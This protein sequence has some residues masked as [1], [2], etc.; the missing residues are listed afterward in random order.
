MASSNCYRRRRSFG[1]RSRVR[2]ASLDLAFREALAA[3]DALMRANFALTSA[4]SSGE[5][6]RPVSAVK[7]A[8]TSSVVGPS[9]AH[10]PMR[11]ISRGFIVI[12][13]LPVCARLHDYVR[14]V[15]FVTCDASCEPRGFERRVVG[16][17][18]RL[19]GP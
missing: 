9:L 2:F 17:I 12:V 6:T 5:G 4:T 14:R 11:R 10:R 3:Q 15:P 16:R 8:T 1:F 19:A 13:L 7:N 18:L